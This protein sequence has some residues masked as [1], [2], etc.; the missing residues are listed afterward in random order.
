MCLIPINEVSARCDII[1]LNTR[2]HL[3][4]HCSSAAAA[5][6]L[7]NKC[8]YLFGVGRVDNTIS[9]RARARS[10]EMNFIILRELFV[11]ACAA[12]TSKVSG[13]AD[14]IKN[15]LIYAGVGPHQTYS[16]LI[17]HNFAY[18]MCISYRIV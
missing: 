18:S 2:A 16:S 5:A 14:Y 3:L 17:N 4:S 9:R 7:T 11:E 15:I 8:T 13:A 10:N 6:A 1:D 12:P